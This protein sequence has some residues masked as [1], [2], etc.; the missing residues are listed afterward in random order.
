MYIAFLPKWTIVVDP[1]NE[2][3]PPPPEETTMVDSVTYGESLIQYYTSPPILQA[4]ETGV[5]LM[6][7]S[8]ENDE[9]YHVRSRKVLPAL[10]FEPMMRMREFTRERDALKSLTKHDDVIQEGDEDNENT[11]SEVDKSEVGV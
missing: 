10:G 5:L 11:N 6:A 1:S 8:N 7:Y 9:F 4:N 2:V 3:E